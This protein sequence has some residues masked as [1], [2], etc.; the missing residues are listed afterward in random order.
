MVILLALM[1]IAGIVFFATFLVTRR[2]LRR[3][4]STAVTPTERYLHSLNVMSFGWV[5]TI[6]LM[7]SFMEL[8]VVTVPIHAWS[9]SIEFLNEALSFFPI[10]SVFWFSLLTIGFLLDGYRLDPRGSHAPVNMLDK[11]WLWT[12]TVLFAMAETVGILTG[13]LI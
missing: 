8:L 10:F 12:L 1:Y 4:R 5:F 11:R 6:T 2:S 13:V 9:F 3:R 7:L